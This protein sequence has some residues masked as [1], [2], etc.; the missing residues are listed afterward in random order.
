MAKTTAAERKASQRT[1]Q[2]AAGEKKLE[3]M[4]DA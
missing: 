1:R 4:L 3:L 2:A